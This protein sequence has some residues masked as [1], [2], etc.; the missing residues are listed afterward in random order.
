MRLGCAF[1]ASATSSH[2]N[3]SSPDPRWKVGLLCLYIGMATGRS[4]STTMSTTL[5]IG[6]PFTIGLGSATVSLGWSESGSRNPRKICQGDP[7]REQFVIY[8][9]YGSGAPVARK[10]R[11][12]SA[13][14]CGFT[15]GYGCCLDLSWSTTPSLGVPSSSIA[16]RSWLGRGIGLPSWRPV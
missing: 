13:S 3:L 14:F 16:D 1:L 5:P 4:F 7:L 12:I 2:S 6:N 11:V 8:G 10:R 15:G 9:L